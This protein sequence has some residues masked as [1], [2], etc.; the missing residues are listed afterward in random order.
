MNIDA[1]LDKAR[2]YIGDVVVEGLTVFFPNY[3]EK[4]GFMDVTLLFDIINYVR[5]GSLNF[6]DIV[7][8]KK[9]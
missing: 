5:K 9:R 7:V 3:G 8:M 1:S 6:Q 4:K 2:G